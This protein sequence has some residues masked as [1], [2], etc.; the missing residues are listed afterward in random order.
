MYHIIPKDKLDEKGERE[1]KP[2]MNLYQLIQSIPEF[3]KDTLEN[4]KD[5]KASNKM[6]G[7]FYLGL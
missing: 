4:A 5:K 6:I 3:I 1:W 7:R 2:S